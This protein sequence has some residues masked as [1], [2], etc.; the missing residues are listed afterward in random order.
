MHTNLKVV[1]PRIERTVVRSR[2]LHLIYHDMFSNDLQLVVDRSYDVVE[3]DLVDYYSAELVSLIDKH[4]PVV[5]KTIIKRNRPKWFTEESV[6]LK[7]KVRRQ[8]RRY[9][10]SIE[11][12]DKEM[13]KNLMKI[14]RNHLNF[15]H[16]K[17]LQEQ[18]ED[19]KFNS[20]S[21]TD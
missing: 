13:F 6:E 3:S 21:C 19:D 18:I 20:K 2:K 5:E 15:Q 11:V 8:E 17:Y 14:Y 4:A 10:C 16:S 1:K 12:N 7:K 9:R